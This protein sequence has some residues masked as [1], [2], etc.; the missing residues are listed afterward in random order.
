MEM[1]PHKA[2]VSLISADKISKFRNKNV[3]AL[4]FLQ[5]SRNLFRAVRE[6]PVQ[7]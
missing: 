3:T 4:F 1:E 7:F 6:S 5:K 2:P